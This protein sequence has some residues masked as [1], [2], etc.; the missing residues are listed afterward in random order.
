MTARQR[1]D[2]LEVAHVC[3]QAATYAPPGYTLDAFMDAAIAWL[4]MPLAQQQARMPQFT[5]AELET[6]KARLLIP[7]RRA[8]LVGR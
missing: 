5:P 4:E 6:I 7:L 1:L 3:H 2:K 8:R